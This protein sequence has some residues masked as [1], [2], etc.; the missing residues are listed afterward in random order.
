MRET[1]SP[2]LVPH[3]AGTV[4]LLGGRRLAYASYGDPHGAPLF[5][6]HGHP[7]SRLE[8]AL[9]HEEALRAGVRLIGVDRPGMGRSDRQPERRIVDWPTDVEQLADGLG[10]DRFAVQGISGGG[11]YAAVVGAALGDRLSSVTLISSAAPAGLG[12]GAGDLAVNELQARLTRWAPWLLDAAFARMSRSITHAR[13]RSD[14]ASVGRSAIEGLP[15]VDRAALD[16]E[17]R[18]ARYGESLV[19]AFRRGRRGAAWDARLLSRSWGF[20][21][22]SIRVPSVQIWQGGLDRNVAPATG[23]LLASAI[24]DAT[25]HF[26][27]AEGHIS[28]AFEHAE[29]IIDPAPS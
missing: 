4:T 14:P 22:A 15:P 29:E 10:L 18:A 3:D 11:P 9:L 27:P 16:P 2:D 5:H 25:L 20:D 7:G 24:P 12:A 28:V 1:T 17:H 19:E 13:G 26:C 21:V 8:A 6:F 23:E